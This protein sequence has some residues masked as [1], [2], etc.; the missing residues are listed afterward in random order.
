MPTM[1][2]LKVL[3]ACNSKKPKLCFDF[4]T[5]QVQVQVQCNLQYSIFKVNNTYVYLFY[6]VPGTKK[7]FLILRSPH[8]NQF[9]WLKILAMP[10]RMLKQA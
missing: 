7:C 2:M 10:I 6:S 8:F 3:R 4:T 9:D 1:E 5:C